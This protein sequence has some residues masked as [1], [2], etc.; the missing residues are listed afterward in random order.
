MSK[1]DALVVL[2][3][4][5]EE[6][7]SLSS[8]AERRVRRALAAYHAAQD[9]G[10]GPLLVFSGGRRWHGLAEA[11]AFR[12][13][14]LAQGVPEASALRELKSLTTLEN[15]VY[16]TRLLRELGLARAGIVTCDWHLPRALRCFSG[17]GLE[18]VGIPARSPTPALGSTRSI[19]WARR[20]LEKGGSRLW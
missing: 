3:C 18:I 9:P 7:G 13:F 19:L 17:R 20:L 16:S 11:D 14:A 8:A 12:Q 5:I 10:G 6:R 15:A 1:L 2:G 4:Q